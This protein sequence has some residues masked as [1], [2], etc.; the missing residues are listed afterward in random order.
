[1]LANIAKASISGVIDPL[2]N[3]S[4]HH[5]QYAVHFPI[6]DSVSDLKY[7]IKYYDFK[8]MNIDMLNHYLAGINWEKILSHYSTIDEA[9]ECFYDVLYTAIVN[10]A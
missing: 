2:L 7:N 9:V 8:N 5:V 3:D 4:H 10:L 1:M 6:K